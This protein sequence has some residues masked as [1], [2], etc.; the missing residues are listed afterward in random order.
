MS[1]ASVA[2]ELLGAVIAARAMEITL[3]EYI[4]NLAMLSQGL[5]LDAIRHNKLTDLAINFTMEDAQMEEFAKVLGDNT[6]LK[7]VEV[8]PEQRAEVIARHILP[9]CPSRIVVFAH[10]TVLDMKNQE[11]SGEF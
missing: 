8:N 7:R 1:F 6:S 11:L 2:W 5:P 10:L 3:Y 9:K 4:V